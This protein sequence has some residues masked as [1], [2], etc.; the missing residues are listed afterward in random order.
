MPDTPLPGV[1]ISTPHTS[2]GECMPS[3][4]NVAH[5]NGLSIAL[6]ASKTNFSLFDASYDGVDG[7]MDPVFENDPAASDRIG[8]DNGR[9]KIDRFAIEGDT[10]ALI[11]RMIADYGF[12]HLAIPTRRGTTR[13]GAVWNI[14]PRSV[15]P[16]GRS[17]GCWTS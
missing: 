12:V 10:E 17:G 3:V 9:D 11:T 13:V 7:P 5:D 8:P 16:T 1:N 6:Y 14:W 4:F 15:S 2:A